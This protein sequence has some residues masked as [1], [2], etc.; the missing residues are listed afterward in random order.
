[1][2]A[3]AGKA[4][5]AL[6][7]FGL[8]LK[9]MTLETLEVIKGCDVLCTDALDEPTLGPLKG[10]C[11]DI[12]CLRDLVKDADPR[13]AAV[14]KVELVLGLV[15]QG[16][17]V[18]VLNYGH[19]TFLSSLSQGLIAAC[20]DRG[21]PYRIFNAVSSLDAVLV[22]L[23]LSALWSGL[24]IYDADDF[25]GTLSVLALQP[26]VPTIIVKVG[27]L[28]KAHQ[29][30]RLEFFLARL[31]EYYPP[32]HP[33]TLVVSPWLADGRGELREAP[34]RGLKAAL[35]GPNEFVTLYLRPVFADD[36]GPSSPLRGVLT[37]AAGDSSLDREL[38]D[39]R[40]LLQEG[41]AAGAEAHFDGLLA[42]RPQWVEARAWRAC[43]R[44]AR[45][46]AAAALEDLDRCVSLRPE[47]EWHFQLRAEARLAAG[48]PGGAL[49]DLEK[50]ELWPHRQ[51]WTFVLRA[52]A[53]AR[54]G[55][56]ALA[57]K[58][59]DRAVGADPGDWRAFVLRGEA[60]LRAG[61]R[62]GGRAD[63]DRARSLD[64]PGEFRC[65]GIVPWRFLL[66]RW[67]KRV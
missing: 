39:G 30:D 43:C 56:W 3:G 60:R 2:D 42:R 13:V 22:S 14:R 28:L 10:L 18:V 66:H 32:E 52:G 51:G 55:D 35:S 8:D 58:A 48:D 26:A 40:A 47:P 24:H 45:R 12:R 38:E 23:E 65:P 57:A 33:V 37:D 6:C 36:R 20:R 59:A 61:D 63:F 49:A 25:G 17:E 67:L 29:K 44:L 64:S 7:G 34:L 62:E 50:A 46:A 9:Q 19:A 4:R 21:V 53:A 27:Y 5:L 1:M 16:K 15:A 41:D 31:G 11:A 54:L